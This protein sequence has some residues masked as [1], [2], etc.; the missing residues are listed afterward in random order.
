ME[1]SPFKELN[2]DKVGILGGEEGKAVIWF[3]PLEIL[4]KHS[5]SSDYKYYYS[6]NDVDDILLSVIKKHG[7]S[8]SVLKSK[9]VDV[10]TADLSSE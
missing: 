5:I 6:I 10:V 7:L 9:E 2:P 1:V 3:I 8:K 4:E